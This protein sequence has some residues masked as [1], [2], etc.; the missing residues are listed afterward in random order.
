M[1][2]EDL[3]DYLLHWT[4]KRDSLNTEQSHNPVNVC[5]GRMTKMVGMLV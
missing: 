5:Q 4:Q 3:Q 2:N 1:Q